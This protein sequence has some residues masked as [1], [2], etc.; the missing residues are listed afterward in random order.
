[1]SMKNIPI[2]ENFFIGIDDEEHQKV[3]NIIGKGK[4]SIAY[5]V[6]DE[7]TSEIMCKKVIIM[8]DDIDAFKTLQNSI[9][10]IEILHKINHPSICKAF[11]SRI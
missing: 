7:R 9:K 4:T 1:M 5:K 11:Q 6:V 8:S 2:N 3:L 10:E